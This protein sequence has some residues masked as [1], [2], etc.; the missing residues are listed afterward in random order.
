MDR[1]KEN[2]KEE[3]SRGKKHNLLLSCTKYVRNLSLQGA[4]FR[5]ESI[6]YPPD[7]SIRKIPGTEEYEFS[8]EIPQFWSILQV[9]N[10]ILVHLSNLL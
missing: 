6:H 8:G 10:N 5:I 9:R 2:D 3:Q 7:A 1:T 4:K